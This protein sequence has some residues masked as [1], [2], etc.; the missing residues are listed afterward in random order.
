MTKITR[1]PRLMRRAHT[2][3]ELLLS[4]D[5]SSTFKFL[6]LSTASLLGARPGHLVTH[7]L[8]HHEYECTVSN[9]HL[10]K[11]AYK[12]CVDNLHESV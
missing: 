9:A 3:Y 2:T 1:R 12:L 10:L 8:T 5:N 11:C 4:D 7:T 6:V